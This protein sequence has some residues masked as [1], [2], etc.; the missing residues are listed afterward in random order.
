MKELRVYTGDRIEGI[1]IKNEMIDKG[2]KVEVEDRL[3]DEKCQIIFTRE[4]E[5]E[6][7]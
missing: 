7:N 2:W 5:D 1:Y 3:E 4:E 6:K